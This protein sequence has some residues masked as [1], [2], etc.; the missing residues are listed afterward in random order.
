MNAL[1]RS[2]RELFPASIYLQN[3]ASI[4]PRTSPNKFVSSSSRE[5]E[6][7]HWNFEPL[8]C[9]PAHGAE[10]EAELRVDGHHPFRN[11][12][13]ERMHRDLNAVHRARDGKK[14]LLDTAYAGLCFPRVRLSWKVRS[15]RDRTIRTIQI[16]VRSKFS[17]NRGD[18]ARIHQKS[19]NFRNVECST[20]STN[21]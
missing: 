14:R 20:C 15:A 8:I 11:R 12:D 5:F 1:C 19:K 13:T 10:V 6:F 7:E 9:S 21:I 3:L 17:Q 18:F 4:Q 16:R 2:R